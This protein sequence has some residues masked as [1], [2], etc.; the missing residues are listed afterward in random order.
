MDIAHLFDVSGKTALVSG[1]SGGIGF[2]IA[3]GVLRAGCKVL[4]VSRK[5]DGV[6][7]ATDCA[8][9]HGRAIPI[10]RARRG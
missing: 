6:T 4:I 3:D 1:G 8:Y 5:L 2:M 10:R 7:A 9:Q